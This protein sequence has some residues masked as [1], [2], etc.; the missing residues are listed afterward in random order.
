MKIP[1][2][3]L[4]DGK[5]TQKSDLRPLIQIKITPGVTAERYLVYFVLL[6][7]SA[8]TIKGIAIIHKSQ[9]IIFSRFLHQRW[10]NITAPLIRRRSSMLR[11]FPVVLFRFRDLLL[12]IPLITALGVMPVP[13][14]VSYCFN[15]PSCF[16]YQKFCYTDIDCNMSL[17]RI[18]D[19]L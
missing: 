17:F 10:H 18:E 15:L 9:S 11:A 2:K 8:N 19:V 7:N 13:P 3:I 5:Q 16:L 4:L 6:T 1:Y 12:T 14:N